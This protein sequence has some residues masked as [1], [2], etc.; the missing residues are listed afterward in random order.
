MNELEAT[1]EAAFRTVSTD[2]LIRRIERAPDFGYDDEAVELTR[3]LRAEGKAWRWAS[4]TRV[5]VSA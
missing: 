5:E 1:I 2:A 3:R 4:D